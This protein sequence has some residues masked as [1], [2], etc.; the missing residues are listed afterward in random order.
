LPAGKYNERKTA[1]TFAAW[2]RMSGGNVNGI[3]LPSEGMI[4]QAP[5][6]DKEFE[7]IWALNMVDLK[8]PDH[9]VV[10]FKLLKKQPLFL[11]WY[12]FDFVFPIT[13]VGSELSS[14]CP[15][16]VFVAIVVMLWSCE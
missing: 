16:R 10:L 1:I 8:D 12:L 13:Q 6:V 9:F 2:V 4:E 15:L 14:V 7:D 3:P 5:P 11:K